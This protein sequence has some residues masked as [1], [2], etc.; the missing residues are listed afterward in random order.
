M[1]RGPDGQVPESEGLAAFGLRW[2]GEV[3]DNDCAVWPDNWPA[4]M[5]FKHMMTQWIMGF[6]G[7]VG[8]RYE[9]LPVVLRLLDLPRKEWS[10]LF[11][12]VRLMES[13]ALDCM[14]EQ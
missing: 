10:S 5:V 11:P 8:L 1:V 9:A 14:H 12:D 4:V 13:T 6:S 2:E 3:P 7:P